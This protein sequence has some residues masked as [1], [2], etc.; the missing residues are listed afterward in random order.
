MFEV[1]SSLVYERVIITELS[2]ADNS[3]VIN[4]LTVTG[5]LIFAL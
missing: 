3:P 2:F 1:L 4:N 5:I